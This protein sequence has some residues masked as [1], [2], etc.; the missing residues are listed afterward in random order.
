M[1]LNDV[2]SLILICLFGYFF[3]TNFRHDN[4][5]YAFVMFIGVMVFYGDFYHH[6]PIN[7]KLYILLIAAFFWA[8]FIILMGRQAMK[9]AN[10]R[11]HF[12]YAAIIGV[13]GIIT[14]VVFRFI[15]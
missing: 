3:V 2:I 12:S 1:V 9:N 15:L 14:T 5:A 7:W 13:I 6:L 8:I 11:K 4:Y 10:S